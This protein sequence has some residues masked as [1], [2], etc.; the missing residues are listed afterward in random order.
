M[1][2]QQ[3]WAAIAARI[4]RL[5]RT[6]EYVTAYLDTTLQPQ[7]TPDFGRSGG[8]ANALRQVCRAETILRQIDLPRSQM[9]V[10]M[11]EGGEN[12]E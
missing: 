10:T 8:G 4:E 3:E 12:A 1:S 5:T 11:R 6:S 2:W 7:K 9:C